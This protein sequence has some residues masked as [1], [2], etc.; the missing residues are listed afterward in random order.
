M[1]TS[2]IHIFNGSNYPCST[3]F[4]LLLP[5]ETDLAI[6]IVVVAMVQL[7]YGG[8]FTVGAYKTHRD[9][10]V[11]FNN[12]IEKHG[13]Y[14]KLY[15]APWTTILSILGFV[16]TFL[17]LTLKDVTHLM[18]IVVSF[19]YGYFEPLLTISDWGFY[20][21]L[22]NL[23]S[24]MVL[25]FGAGI[26]FSIIVQVETYFIMRVCAYHMEFIQKGTK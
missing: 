12:V 11:S 10:P 21:A 3:H 7:L 6:F 25:I 4:F 14:M 26:A 16:C 17:S 22:V 15:L 1:D 9:D 23:D 8:I 13:N 19:Y 20:K 5:G 2:N 18:A 24:R